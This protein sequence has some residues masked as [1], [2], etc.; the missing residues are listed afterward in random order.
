[1]IARFRPPFAVRRRDDPCARGARRG[2]ERAAAAR[3]AFAPLAFAAAA[4]LAWTPAGFAAGTLV[5]AVKTGDRAAA[6]EMIARGADVDAA[7]AN[8]TTPLHWAV[9]RE[10][11]ALVERLLD[12]GAD[13]SVENDFGSTPM[14]EAAV[15]GNAEIIRLLLDAGA[16]PE[17]PNAEG[18]TALM[19]V[20]RT[21]DLEA[22]KL[23]LDAGADV[24]ATEH[25]GGQSALMWAAVQCHPEMMRLLIEHGAEVDARGA[26]RNW[27]RRVTAEPR[28]KDLHR[29]GFTPLLYAAREG[30]VDGARVLVEAGADIDLADPDRVTPLVLALINMRFDTAAYLIEAGAD[31][32]KWDFYGRTPLYAAVDLSTLPR[33]GRPD[34]PST[35]ETTALEVIRMLLE[36]GANPNIQLKWRPPYRNVIFDRGGD[37]AVLTTGATPLLRASK[38]GD[39]LEAIRLLLA[40]GARVDLP[41]EA[42]ITP[43]MAAAG[44]GHSDNPTRG[45]FN[46]EDDGI[47]AL[48]VLLEAGADINARNADGQTALH[49]AAQ[50]GWTKVVKFLA[51][52]GAELDVK[53]A[54]GRTPLDYAS[55]NYRVRRG[56]PEAHPETAAVLEELLGR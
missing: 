54:A 36:R 43:L 7:E 25:W 41:N 33:G 44:M 19:A 15:T 29:G 17:S 5:D 49:A 12:A 11:V 16:D 48:R 28:P 50:K 27:Q 34:V 47:A 24:N 56:A 42:G 51:A 37:N 40:H 52:N 55:G 30:C 32:D 23:L 6:L 45:R 46:T 20:A 53:D 13:P 8:G 3:I 22:A 4:F 10:D 31:V 2:T 14:A 9:Y 26:V 38:V 35:D 18:Q 21:G 1:M 39:N